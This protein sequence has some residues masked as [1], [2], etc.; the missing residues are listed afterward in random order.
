[1]PLGCLFSPEP[2]GEG[3]CGP[4]RTHG[5]REGHCRQLHL[6]Q[7]SAEHRAHDVGHEVQ[8]LEEELED[9][10]HGQGPLSPADPSQPGPTRGALQALR[11]GAKTRKSPSRPQGKSPRAGERACE[12]AAAARLGDGRP[13]SHPIPRCATALTPEPRSPRQAAPSTGAGEGTAGDAIVT[14]SSGHAQRSGVQDTKT[15][16]TALSRGWD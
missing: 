5:H 13:G 9:G 4:G 8:H 1:M 14:S 16:G 12:A 7:V 3:P 6:A 15:L 11:G 10:G 2:R